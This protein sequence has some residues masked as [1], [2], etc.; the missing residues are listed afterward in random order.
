[1][2]VGII[3]LGLI[4]TSLAL[5]LKSVYKD[6]TLWGV[7]INEWVLKYFETKNIFINLSNNINSIASLIKETDFIFISVYPSKVSYVLEN[8]KEFLKEETIVTDTAST[9]KKIMD[10]VNNDEFLNRVFIGGHPL[11]GREITGPEGALKDLFERKVYFLTPAKNV[12]FEK[13][14]SLKKLINSI[15]SYPYLISPEKHDEILA[16]TSHLP[17]VIAYLLSYVAIK[18]DNIDF[19]GSGFKD[20]TRIAKSDCNLWIDILKENSQEIKIALEEVYSLL[21][22]LI[23]YLNSEDYISVQ[24]IFEKSREKRLKLRDT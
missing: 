15:G 20:T 18:E 13:I 19:F 22:E 11:A 12:S 3:G 10:Y 14:D 9:K 24:R 2:I 21:G 4:G 17:Q 5:G 6:I 23:N 1:M 7:D 16:Y 8:L